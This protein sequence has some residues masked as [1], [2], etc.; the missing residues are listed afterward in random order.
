M[1]RFYVDRING[2][3]V[4][5]TDAAQFH[6]LKNVLRLKI[7]ERL[8][9]FDSDGNEYAGAVTAIERKQAVIK[10]TAPQPLLS[11]QVKLTLA[12]AIPKGDRMDDIIDQLTQL[13]VE[14]VI[15]M[16]TER[17][18]VK[19]DE[20]KKASRLKRWRTIVQNAARQSQRNSLPV[21][22]PVTSLAE[23]IA[24]SGDFDLKL[25]PHLSGERKLIKDVL[26]AAKLTNILVLV[27]PEGDF[28]PEEV[29]QALDAG[30]I[31]VSLGNTVLRVATAAVAVAS[32][33][34]FSLGE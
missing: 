14:R 7:G 9:V 34:K 8:A 24:K 5:I 20:V 2:D 19:L 31:P 30:F 6:H 33:L 32:Y 15:P 27:G 28:T 25:I 17:V 21:I 11:R 16:W 1:H 22:E 4:A 12:C 10:V 13:G 3:T 23:V 29:G 26:I 18:V